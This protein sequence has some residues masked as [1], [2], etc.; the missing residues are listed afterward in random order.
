VSAHVREHVAAGGDQLAVGEVDEAHDAEDEADADGDEPVD[1]AERDRVRD[2]L[3]P[4]HE[5]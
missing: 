5:R 1:R 2:S 3:A 4:V